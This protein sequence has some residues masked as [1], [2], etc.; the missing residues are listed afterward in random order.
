LTPGG[1][2]WYVT[3]F[4]SHGEESVP[5]YD[6]IV[7][8]AGHAG[9]E[10]ALAGARMGCRTLLLT[11]NL[12][13]IGHM[14]CSPSIGGLGKSHLVKE[15]D[16]LGGEMGRIADL[17]AIQYRVLNTSKGP[18]VQGTRTQNDKVRYRIAMKRTLESQSGL[19]IKQAQAAEI[20]VEGGH[21]AGIRDSVGAVF[22]AREVV[23]T[24]GTFLHGLVHIGNT[25]I[26]AGRAGEF[27]SNDLAESLVRLG[28]RTGRFKTGTPMRV[29]RGS[30]DFSRFEEQRGDPVYTPFSH[31]TENIPLPQVS[32]HI[33]RTTERTHEIIRDN[34]RLSALYSGAI[35][36]TP[37]R[38]CPSIEDKIVRFPGRASHQIILEPEGLD[39]E[40]IYVGGTGNSL[41]YEVQIEL[42]HSIP[43]LEE[44]EIM[45][46]AYAIEYD[47]VLP[48]Q[49]S[50][51]L[52][53]KLV[54]GLSLAGQVNGTSGYEEAAAQGFI[55]GV[56]AA[57]RVQG[58]PPFVLGRAEGYMGVMADDLAT[59]GVEEPY[60]MFTSRA[61]HRLLF[62]E[63][64]AEYRLLEK[65][66][67]LGLRSRED[68]DRLREKDRLVREEMDRFARTRVKPSPVANSLFAAK[69]TTPLDQPA[70]LAQLLKRPELR[71]EDISPLDSDAPELP[72]DVRR[73]AE[74]RCTYEGY[75]A[76]QESEAAKLRDLDRIAIPP[77][78]DYASIA[79]LSNEI[80][81]KLCEI[82]PLTLGQASRMSGMTPSAISLLMIHL[83]KR[84]TEE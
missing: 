1:P 30:I 7:V 57:L 77:D 18:A 65:G 46:P 54:C 63:D 74:I 42:L 28:F 27:P 36:G 10:A 8:G 26:P 56:N 84:R 72:A 3:V 41:P 11:M 75:L 82:R 43:G 52:E 33:V 48:T 15:I 21:V 32:C 78:T 31:A 29:G 5:E 79:A 16:A 58:R 62:R 37:A 44:A 2:G 59:R 73:Q 4:D 51:T 49:L 61:E 80:R 76:R 14:P 69:G 12:D 25:R 19:R 6:I 9:C 47:Y 45:R 64:N 71:Y 83:K 39:T 68:L 55:A 13:T 34:L 50:P 20:I 70:S 53:T 23:I 66:F 24:A 22:P 81:R 67:E 17:S 38:Y 35:T 60:R 40:E